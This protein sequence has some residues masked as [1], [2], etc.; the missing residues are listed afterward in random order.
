MIKTQVEV[1]SC[2]PAIS[3]K[4]KRYFI[5]ALRVEG[6]LQDMYSPKEYALGI[7]EMQFS[8]RKSLRGNDL[9][10]SLWGVPENQETPQEKPKSGK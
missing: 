4:G 7:Q 8:V 2:T 10:L 9:V 1:Y 5:V 6:V 3:K